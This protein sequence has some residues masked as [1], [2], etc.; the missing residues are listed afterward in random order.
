MEILK[1]KKSTSSNLHLLSVNTVMD[2]PEPIVMRLDLFAF[3]MIMIKYIF[4]EYYFLLCNI[5]KNARLRIQNG[6]IDALVPNS[7]CDQ[8]GFIFSLSSIVLE[9]F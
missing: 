8:S 1:I 2:S 7:S 6:I 4:I 9:N 3:H 5:I